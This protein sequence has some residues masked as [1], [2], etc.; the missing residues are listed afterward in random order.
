MH[1]TPLRKKRT[2]YSAIALLETQSFFLWFLVI[3]ICGL[4]WKMCLF[5]HPTFFSAYIIPTTHFI[6]YNILIS[7]RARSVKT[8]IFEFHHIF[9]PTYFQK[10]KFQYDISSVFPRKNLS[11]RVQ[12][13]PTV[14]TDSAGLNSTKRIYLC[15]LGSFT[16][17]SP[18]QKKSW[19]WF[20]ID[21]RL[22]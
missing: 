21:W 19:T 10:V 8:A 14:R 11:K 7:L 15:D 18:K 16:I 6:L 4:W 22:V 1:K 13:N 12:I 20:D 17:I 3:E 5:L 9:C 2:V